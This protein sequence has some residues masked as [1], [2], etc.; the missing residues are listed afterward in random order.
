MPAER[1]EHTHIG[2]QAVLEGVMMRGKANWAIAIRQPDGDI[3]VE[4][5]ELP[6]AS[7]A[8]TWK[9]WPVVRGVVALYDTMV[10]AMQAFTISASYAGVAVPDEGAGGEGETAE[11]F[12]SLS[13][14][15]IGF[16]LALGLVGAVVIFIVL[17]ALVTSAVAWLVPGLRTSLAWN[18]IDGL[19]RVLVFFGY[20]WGI[21]RLPDIQ[22]LFAY[23]GAEHK[24]IHA[25]EHGS[26]LEPEPVQQFETMHVRCGTSFL[27]MVMIVA[28]FVFSLLPTVGLWG[29]VGIKIGLR[30]ALL[31]LI[32]GLAYEV[33]HYAGRHSDNSMIK[34]L[35]WPGLMLQKMTTR[36]PDDRMV[37]VAVMAVLPVLEREEIDAPLPDGDWVAPEFRVVAPQGPADVLPDRE[38]S[39]DDAGPTAD[40]VATAVSSAALARSARADVDPA[41]A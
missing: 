21:S 26:P 10:L 2:G 24:T 4:Q 34:I 38:L 27:L 33:I 15:E 7:G 16:S 36:E 6:S 23:H 22:R 35:L 8:G 40:R 30:I 39:A 19:L 41:D 29:N 31:P 37:E 13:A 32:A 12:E 17:P 9:Q 25:Y 18:V 1:I 11:G 28:I 5:H 3:H 20:I 14:R